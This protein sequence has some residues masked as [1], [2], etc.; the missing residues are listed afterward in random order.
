MWAGNCNHGTYQ[1]TSVKSFTIIQ[2]ILD[3]MRYSGMQNTCL[4][5]AGQLSHEFPL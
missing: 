2:L 4:V 1:L 3:I 5:Y